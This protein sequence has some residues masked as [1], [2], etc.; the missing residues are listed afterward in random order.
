MGRRKRAGMEN[1][2]KKL[3]LENELLAVTIL[4]ELGGKVASF[5]YKPLDFELAAQSPDGSYRL[6]AAACAAAA[7]S[8]ACIVY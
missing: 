1:T 6:P 7:F 4:P 3:V 2:I 8:L 5:C